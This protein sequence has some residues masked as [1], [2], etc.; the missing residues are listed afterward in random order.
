MNRPT[1]KTPGGRAY[2]DLQNRARREGRATQELF[3]LYVLERWLARLA[4][5]P[6]AGT[7]VL[8][9]G[10]L[11]AVLGARRPTAD[12]DLL[13]RNMVNDQ[14]VVLERVREIARVVPDEDD[15]VEFLTETL[16][17]QAI[18][19]DNLYAGVRLT[20]SCSLGGAVVKLKLDINFGDPV[21]PGARELTLPAQRP[22]EPG[23]PVL[24]YPIE[25]VIA[26]KVSTAIALGEANTRVRDYADLYTLMTKHSLSYASVRAAFDAT[27]SHR[28]V[29]PRPLSDVVGSLAELRAS[30]YRAFRKR[31]GADGAHL[32]EDFREVVDAALGF[33]D[34]LVERQPEGSTWSPTTGWEQPT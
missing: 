4:V 1:K 26:E 6:R 24:G 18:R 9:G 17:S 28:G 29:E 3:T 13:A 27:T 22:G 12:I 7:F 16:V 31:L 33:V 2:L 5:S 32:P 34:P 14:V 25:T 8:K 23:I 15:G 10:V 21:T 11:L 20:M 30:A 19:E